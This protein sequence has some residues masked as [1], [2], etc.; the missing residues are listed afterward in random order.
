MEAETMATAPNMVLV[1]LLLC[2]PIIYGFV[3]WNDAVRA[4]II[5]GVLA[6]VCWH[7]FA[8]LR[9]DHRRIFASVGCAIGGLLTAIGG[10]AGAVANAIMVASQQQTKNTAVIAEYYR[11]LKAREDAQQRIETLSS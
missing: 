8:L 3:V 2:S 7:G 6:N 11:A 10:T 5:A 9:S 1:L 4:T